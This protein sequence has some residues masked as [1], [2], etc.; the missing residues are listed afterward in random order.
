MH[1]RH[2]ELVVWRIWWRGDRIRLFC[3]NDYIHDLWKPGVSIGSRSGC[4]CR[5]RLYTCMDV[6]GSGDC[7]IASCDYSVTV[8]R[9]AISDRCVSDCA[10]PSRHGCLPQLHPCDNAN[11]ARRQLQLLPIGHR[12]IKCCIMYKNYRTY[13]CSYR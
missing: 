2:C 5:M 7:N 1:K 12:V 3:N 11:Y 9:P 13:I 6:S 4:S 8:F 10:V